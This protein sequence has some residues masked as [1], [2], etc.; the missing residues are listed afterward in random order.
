MRK[1]SNY[2]PKGVI[3]DTMRWLK[4]GMTLMSAHPAA[5]DLRIKNHACLTALT[6]GEGQPHDI[7]VMISA[8]NI[9]EALAMLRIGTEYKAEILAAQNALLTMTR[10]GIELGNR[11]LFTGPE[12]TAVNL[13]M[14]IHDAQLDACT[15]AELEQAIQIVE[16]VIKQ[17]LAR[18]IEAPEVKA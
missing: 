8:L 1:R 4:Q 17:N 16:S 13:G 10:R 5:V 9:T 14:E 18:R 2:R 12:L 3:M 7:D 11:F 6:R 15:V